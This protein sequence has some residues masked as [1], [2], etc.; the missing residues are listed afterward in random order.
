MSGGL[1]LPNRLPW[2]PFYAVDWLADY[3]VRQLTL[4]HRGIYIDLLAWQWREEWIPDDPDIAC[5]VLGVAPGSPQA[6]AVDHILNCYF[7]RDDTHPGRRRNTRLDAIRMQQEADHLSRQTWGK[8]GRDKQLRGR[9][10]KPRPGPGRTRGGARQEVEVEV[11]SEVETTPPAPHG[12]VKADRRKHETWLTIYGEAWTARF[13][14][15]PP[16]KQMAAYFAGLQKDKGP[17]HLLAAWKNYLGQADALHASPARF[18]QT[19]GSWAG[20]NGAG[21]TPGPRYPTADEA[22]RRAGIPVKG[23]PPPEAR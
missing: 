6:G 21:R 1:P 11:E 10:G 12:A 23:D 22:D 7:P 16:W 18:Y 20:G 8:E 3:A 19:Y 17:V 4:E 9:R 5:R 15:E 2:F 13:E 14:G